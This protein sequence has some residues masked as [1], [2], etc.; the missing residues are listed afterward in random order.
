MDSRSF[1]RSYRV[2]VYGYG[3]NTLVGYTGFMSMFADVADRLFDR[4]ARCKD[5]V[6]V[7]RLRRGYKVSFYYR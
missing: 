3:L 6:C 2:K 7:C 1:N 4:A 5:D